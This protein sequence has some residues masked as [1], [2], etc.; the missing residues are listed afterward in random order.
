[1]YQYGG[2]IKFLIGAEGRSGMWARYNYGGAIG[3]SIQELG[4]VC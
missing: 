2:A 4:M 3:I 1:M